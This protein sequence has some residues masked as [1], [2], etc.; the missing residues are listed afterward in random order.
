M[1]Q[2]CLFY[3]DCID[4]VDKAAF[5]FVFQPERQLD[6]DAAVVEKY[7]PIRRSNGEAR[8][9]PHEYIPVDCWP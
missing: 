6:D 2:R 3:H 5:D 9:L 7:K 4:F 1:G 8:Q